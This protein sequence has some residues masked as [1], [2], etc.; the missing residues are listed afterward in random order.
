LGKHTF[1][2]PI[3]FASRSFSLECTLRGPLPRAL[4]ACRTSAD[5][6]PGL[7]SAGLHRRHCPPESET[8]L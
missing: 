2:T 1:F 5:D 6:P 4:A 3:S 8:R 7:A